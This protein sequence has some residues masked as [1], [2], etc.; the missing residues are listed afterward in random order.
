[1][2]LHQQIPLLTLPENFSNLYRLPPQVLTR[3]KETLLKVLN[4]RVERPAQVALFTYKN[5][6]FIAESF[7]AQSSEVRIV[8]NQAWGS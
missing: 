5:H 4:V 2:A 1:M 6:T 8:T 3:I 7:L